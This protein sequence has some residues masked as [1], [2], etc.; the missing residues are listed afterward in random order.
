MLRAARRRVSSALRRARP[1]SISRRSA[2]K[3]PAFDR[4]CWFEAKREQVREVCLSQT[5]SLL[6]DFVD[7]PLFER[8]T[9]PATDSADR[10]RYRSALYNI[11]TLFYYE[12]DQQQSVVSTVAHG[13]DYCMFSD[14]SNTGNDPARRRKKK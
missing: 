1:R 11:A 14:R 2:D 13:Q 10:F 7:R 6:W 12:A 9:S 8:I 5:D 4:A 3:P